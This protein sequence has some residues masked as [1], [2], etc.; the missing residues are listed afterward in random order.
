MGLQLADS[1]PNIA[2]L[3]D[4]TRPTKLAEMFDNLYDDEYTDAFEEL[5]VEYNNNRETCEVLLQLLLVCIE[6][7]IS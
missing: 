7:A 1:N 2:D 5:D 6:T 4:A 3:S